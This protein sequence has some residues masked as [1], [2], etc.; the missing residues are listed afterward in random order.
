MGLYNQAGYERLAIGI[1][2]VI[3]VL[4]FLLSAANND[5]FAYSLIGSVVSALIAYA[6]T[7]LVYWIIDGFKSHK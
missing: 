5:E 7:R 2:V 3:F 6:L 4:V 1:S